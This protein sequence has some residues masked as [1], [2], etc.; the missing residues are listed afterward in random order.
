MHID[1][2]NLILVY[3]ITF[4]DFVI[5][6]MYITA[7]V[8]VIFFLNWLCCKGDNFLLYPYYNISMV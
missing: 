1:R 8:C 2:L 5:P 4:V 7:A 3:I 6:E